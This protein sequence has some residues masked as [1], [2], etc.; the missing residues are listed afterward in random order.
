M[1]FTT[2]GTRNATAH[3]E[4]LPGALVAHTWLLRQRFATPGATPGRGGPVV[5]EEPCG[6]HPEAIGQ[7]MQDVEAYGLPAG[8]RID[9]AVPADAGSLSQSLLREIPIKP[10]TA[11]SG[12]HLQT[13]AHEP[14]V[15][16]GLARHP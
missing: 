15:D 10:E 14:W 1:N 8:L 7:L 5:A 6:R 9:D 12:T 3:A 2:R 11:D 13:L 4:P 16:G